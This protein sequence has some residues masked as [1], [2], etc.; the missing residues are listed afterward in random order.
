MRGGKPQSTDN[1]TVRQSSSGKIWAAAM[2]TEL[3]KYA[4]SREMTKV[5]KHMGLILQTEKKPY[6]I[7]T[8]LK[9]L[10]LRKIILKKAKLGKKRY[11]TNNIQR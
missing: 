5:Y 4:S 6:K 9:M 11:K 8:Y 10:L 1:I 2:C 7:N 3:Q